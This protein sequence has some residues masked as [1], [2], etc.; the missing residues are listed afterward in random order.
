MANNILNVKVEPADLNWGQQETTLVTMV[1][2]VAGSLNSTYW[3]FDTPT[4]GTDA[5]E[6]IYVWYNVNAAG[7]DPTPAGRTGIE[8]A[9]ATGAS[10]ATVISSTVTAINGDGV[11]AHAAADYASSTK[12]RLQNENVGTVTDAA[13]GAASPAFT[14][15]VERQGA[16]LD[17]GFLDGAVEIALGEDLFDVVAQQTGTNIEDS[18]RTGKNIDAISVSLKE[19]DAARLKILLEAAGAS[20]TP[21][22]GTVVTGYGNSQDFSNVV[23]D[24]RKLTFHPVRLTSINDHTDDWA[25]FRAYPNVSGINFSG[26]SDQLVTVDFRIYPDPVVLQS[27]RLF[28]RGNHTQNLLRV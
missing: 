17:L 20:V 1:A 21:A 16:S 22:G 10:I 24:C 6:L 12:M 4:F 5:A 3:T 9:L 26:D 27:V 15:L 14:F 28:V 19:S 23:S 8:V 13:N 11:L 7:V 2:D 18:I 25:F